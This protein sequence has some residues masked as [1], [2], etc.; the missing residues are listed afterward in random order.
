M[1]YRNILT[2]ITVATIAASSLVANSIDSTFAAGGI[3]ANVLPT[4]TSKLRPPVA[5]RTLIFTD[6][7]FDGIA[8]KKSNAQ[9]KQEPTP[10]EY[11][12]M[13][14]EATERPFTGE[15]N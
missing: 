11:M 14:Q 1:K 13:R 9:W 8:I 7:E 12:V 4:P 15:Y 5:K 2:I 10:N 3:E 6:G